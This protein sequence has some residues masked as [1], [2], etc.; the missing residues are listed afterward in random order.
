MSTRADD[1]KQEA[2]KALKSKKVLVA[3]VEALEGSSRRERQNSSAILA[4]VAKEDPSIVAPYA[5]EIT[6]ALN[7][8][9]AQTRWEALDTLTQI[10]DIDSKAC[11]KALPGAETALFDEDS[12]PLRLSAMRFL[13]HW[14]A[15]TENRSEKV[16][17]LIDEA[18]QCYHGDLEYQD[19]LLAVID[20]STGK[21]AQSVKDEL[22]L[23][24]K[25][26]AENGK[27][28]LKRR[29]AQIIENVAK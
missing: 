28:W 15:T 11:E 20:L 3:H 8:P 21:I 26:D 24:F 23:R 5:S 9:E 10:V 2:D 16:W 29:S 14:G 22:I 6:D 27:G 18:V 1:V 25:F 19:M 17:A 4:A 7:R 12:G 13:C